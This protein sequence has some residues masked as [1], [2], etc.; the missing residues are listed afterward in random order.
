KIKDGV[1]QPVYTSGY[2]KN[3]APPVTFNNIDL[4]LTN[5]PYTIE[6]WSFD[7]VNGDHFGGSYSI[8]SS[9]GIQP[10]SDTKNNGTYLIGNPALDA[11]WGM[12]KTYDFYL[13]VFNRNSYDGKGSVIK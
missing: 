10:W 9:A 5:P 12:E 4:I 3:T 13:N 7:A 11:H 1:S 2:F 8:S 6:V